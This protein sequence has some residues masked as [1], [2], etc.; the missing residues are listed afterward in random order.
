MAITFKK[1]LQ[2]AFLTTLLS[3]LLFGMGEANTQVDFRAV[4]KAEAVNVQNGKHK[5]FCSVCGMTLHSF[6]KTNFAANANGVEK[7]YCSIVCL[8][9]DEIVN[10]QK[11]KNIRV[12]DNLT[13]KM[14]DAKEA[15]YV[16]GSNKPGTM[17]AVSIYGFG[18]IAGAK[19]FIGKNGGELK[20]FNDIYA[21]VKST[22]AKDMAATKERQAKS[23]K[24]GEM[25]YA[26]MCIKTDKKFKSVAEAKSYLE[27]SKICGNIN[28]KQLQAIGLYLV[29]K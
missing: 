21:M 1:I 12:V 3:T 28:D 19:D 11:M 8:V 2:S 24:M 9:E 20:N 27:E 26:K 25:I 17:S 13:M 29:Q 15:S 23:A 7:Q 10:N 22:Q 5:E 16:V 18:T 4:S 14:I 6:Y